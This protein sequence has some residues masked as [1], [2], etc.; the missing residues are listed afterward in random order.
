MVVEIP[1]LVKQGVEFIEGGG[2][3]AGAEP[4]LEG[5]PEPFDLA[6]GLR[7]GRGRVDGVCAQGAPVASNADSKACSRPV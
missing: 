2:G 1:E 6:A 4:F 5:L 7:M 3:W